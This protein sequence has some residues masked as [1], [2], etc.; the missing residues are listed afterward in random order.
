MKRGL[1]IMLTYCLVAVSLLSASAD[2]LDLNDLPIEVFNFQEEFFRV[3]DVNSVIIET[4]TFTKNATDD[5][6]PF[7]SYDSEPISGAKV[8]VTY[9]NDSIVSFYISISENDNYASKKLAD[10]GLSFLMGAA[11][12]DRDR[13][14]SLFEYLIEELEPAGIFGRQSEIKQEGYTATL[15]VAPTGMLSIAIYPD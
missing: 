7:I 15:G 2:S 1:L 10:L 9:R 13:A 3:L 6:P 12:L 8:S 5:D 14:Y 11:N 4:K